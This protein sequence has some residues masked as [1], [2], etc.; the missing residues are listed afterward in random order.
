[1]GNQNQTFVVGYPLIAETLSKVC[2]FVKAIWYMTQVVRIVQHIWL[3]I[4]TNNF[5]MQVIIMLTNRK[6]QKK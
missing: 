1:M 4:I 5:V 6:M 3:G 2:I